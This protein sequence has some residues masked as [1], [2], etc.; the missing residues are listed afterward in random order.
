MGNSGGNSK[1]QNAHRNADG[2]REV[3]EEN[4]DSGGDWTRGHS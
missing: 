2:A 1:A 4:E 3:S